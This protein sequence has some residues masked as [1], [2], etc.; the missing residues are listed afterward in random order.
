MTTAAFLAVLCAAAL[1]AGWNAI[2]KTNADRFFSIAALTVAAGAISAAALPFVGGLS[3]AAWPWLAG[4]L[5]A[6][7]GYKLF[8]ARAYQLGDMGQVYPIARGAAPLLTACAMA[9]L[10]E[11]LSPLAFAGVGILA[12]G[13][14]LMSLRGGRSLVQT[15]KGA[16]GAALITAVWIMGY[17]I[18][19]GMGARAS[20]DPRAYALWLFFCDGVAMFAALRILRG[21]E[22]WRRLTRTGWPEWVG[23][24][25]SMGAYSIAIWAATVSPIALVAA[26]RETSVLFAA[27]ISA[28]IL[29]EPP[30]RARLVAALTILCGVVLA[31]LG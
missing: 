31:R 17:T 15:E 2:V 29:R 11:P 4:S 22:G 28:A 1:H 25:M 26:L 10:G 6:H 18:L 8:L 7:T 16:V 27:L 21:A 9:A 24:V 13:I 12:A 23:G 3:P 19:D 5:V 30:T 20:G 14:A